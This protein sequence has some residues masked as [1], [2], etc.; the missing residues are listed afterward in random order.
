V[1]KAETGGRGVDVILDMVGGDYVDRNIRS[2]ADDGRLV[3]IGYQAG[4]K[5]TVD[6]MRVMLKR[7]T[8]TGSTLRIRP[9]EVKGEIAR[10]VALHALPLVASRKVR[11]V[12]DSTV[13]LTRAAEAHARME[14]SQHIGK[15]V[16]TVG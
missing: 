3:N 6:M 16:L 14:T 2:L 13:P 8:L 5:V 11:I 12:V 1:V 7:L 15:I 10:A 9:T 4:S